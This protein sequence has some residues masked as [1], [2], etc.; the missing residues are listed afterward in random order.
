MPP[1]GRT[2][3]F[4][5][6]MS[7]WFDAQMALNL[8]TSTSVT[9]IASLGAGIRYNVHVFA[10][11]DSTMNIKEYVCATRMSGSFIIRTLSTLPS[12][13]PSM[14]QQ[15]ASN[16]THVTVSWR[17]VAPMYWGDDVLGY[18]FTMTV[19]ANQMNVNPKLASVSTAQTELSDSVSTTME[20]NLPLP[21][22]FV[23]FSLSLSAFNRQGV[24]MVSS[25]AIEVMTEQA[26][27]ICI[28]DLG[29]QYDIMS[30]FAA[31][32]AAPLNVNASVVNGIVVVTWD[33]IA[34]HQINGILASY[35]VK[36]R[37]LHNSNEIQSGCE[38]SLFTMTAEVRDRM[39]QISQAGYGFGIEVAG[40]TAGGVGV[41]SDC[42]VAGTPS[43]QST[44]S[45][46]T[47][48]GIGV[49]VGAAAVV[50]IIVVLLVYYRRFKRRV[51]RR[52]RTITYDGPDKEQESTESL[53]EL[54]IDRRTVDIQRIIGEGQF[55]VVAHGKT[56]MTSEV[57]VA[58]K[59]VK[60][61]ADV[62]QKEQFRYE[63]HRMSK[64]RHVNVVQ[65]LGVCFQS[66]PSF[67]LLE[68]MEHGDVKTYLKRCQSEHPG[69]IRVAQCVKL[70]ADLA[71]GFAYLV[72]SKFVHRDIAARNAL[73][74]SKFTAKIGDFGLLHR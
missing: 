29:L 40:K 12:G 64:L 35:V 30:D 6:S 66:E 51:S 11:A 36:Y 20:W 25:I 62:P 4:V 43:P 50:V 1:S 2:Y 53:D 13:Q 63:A 22:S 38:P 72:A 3:N 65:L 69:R 9:T 48:I 27:K 10:E 14:V 68:Y 23:R 26:G 46:A 39:W 57:D 71:A 18:R 44:S 45:S 15:S 8:S 19:S 37:V 74:D 5:I 61:D 24:A 31:P 54:E 41:F 7:P 56:T 55:G 52:I 70:C 58:V 59:F 28:C 49:G 33:A 16:G 17:A 21:Q 67:I 32:S 60:Q 34:I 42:I 73:I 47:V